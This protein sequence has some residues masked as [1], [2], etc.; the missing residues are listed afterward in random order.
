MTTGRA[1]VTVKFNLGRPIAGGMS[2]EAVLGRVDQI[3]AYQQA[4]LDP[5][6]LAST[7][8]ASSSSGFAAQLASAQDAQSSGSSAV[9]ADTMSSGA[10]SPY[11]SG[12][13]PT[14]LGVSGLG[15]A[16]GLSGAARMLA[17]AKAAVGGAYNQGNHDAVSDSAS[18]IQQQGTDCSGFVSYLMGP[19]GVGDW[20]QSYAT[21]GIPTA[22][23]VQPGA[24]SYVTIW[25][26]PN[27]GNAG[28]VWIEILGQYFESSGSGGVHQ[29]DQSE[30]DQYLKSGQ[31]QP[32]HPAGM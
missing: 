29:M 16:T 8:S 18:Q 9:A 21:P 14:T 11:A 10:L 15:A 31:Y 24:G 17:A 4:I 5:A 3:L 12:T 22:P 6:T 23:G 25:N 1:R 26:N 20:S 19:N 32:F 13:V 28:H 27:P 2:L 7:A 30:V